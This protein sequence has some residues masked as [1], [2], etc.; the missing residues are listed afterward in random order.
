M[1]ARRSAVV[2]LGVFRACVAGGCRQLTWFINEG[3]GD[4]DFLDS[5]AAVHGSRK[6]FEHDR[7]IRRL[8][9][10]NSFFS[11]VSSGLNSI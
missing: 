8:F 4:A 6:E 10:L 11:D 7:T 5:L 9:N 1:E 2:F 3:S